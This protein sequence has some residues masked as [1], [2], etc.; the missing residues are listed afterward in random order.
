[1]HDHLNTTDIRVGGIYTNG[2][3]LFRRVTGTARTGSWV[4]VVY[5]AYR[6]DK[7]G[8]MVMATVRGRHADLAVGLWSFAEWA[9]REATEA[10]AA[11]VLGV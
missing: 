3:G 8:R 11:E 9:H 4:D 6:R 2:A 10:E 5:S 7:A 1:M